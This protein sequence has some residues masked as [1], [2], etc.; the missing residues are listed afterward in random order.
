MVWNPT[1]IKS[2]YRKLSVNYH[3]DYVRSIIIIVRNVGT[4]IREVHFDN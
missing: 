2:I 1:D 3:N 4:I